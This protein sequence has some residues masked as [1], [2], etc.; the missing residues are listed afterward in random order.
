MARQLDHAGAGADRARPYRVRPRLDR[1]VARDVLGTSERLHGSG[2][3]AFIQQNADFLAVGRV[4]GSAQLG[5]YTMAF[6]LSEV[7]YWAIADPAAKV[8]FPSFRGCDTRGRRDAV[9]PVGAPPDRPRVP[10]AGRAAERHGG[11]IHGR[12]LR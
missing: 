12:L 10:A 3:V 8:T 4:L 5:L 11:P 6:R 7:P 1:A 2:G 9:V